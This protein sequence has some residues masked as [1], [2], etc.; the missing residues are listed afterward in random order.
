MRATIPKLQCIVDIVESGVDHNKKANS[1]TSYWM[2]SQTIKKEI[3]LMCF[4]E[5]DANC[6]ET[7]R[8]YKEAVGTTDHVLGL[9]YAPRSNIIHTH[10]D[11]HPPSAADYKHM[12]QSYFAYKTLGH[13]VVT[14][15]HIWH[16]CA[17]SA[18]LGKIQNALIAADVVMLSEIMSSMTSQIS[19]ANK[20][21]INSCDVHMYRR[22][23]ND[24]GFNVSIETVDHVFDH[25]FDHDQKYENEKNPSNTII[26]ALN[27]TATIALPLDAVT[28]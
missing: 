2:K 16:Y 6:A 15:K 5:S 22:T 28:I 12:I 10:L 11:H 8:I 7:P 9:Q 25:V 19:T 13:S 24:I 1:W 14:S 20:E 17:K 4:Y 23:L 3:V 27:S 21:F 26:L 18:I